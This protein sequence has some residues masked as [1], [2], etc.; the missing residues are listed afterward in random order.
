M[1]C[2]I[3]AARGVAHACRLWQLKKKT[4]LLLC[5]DNY[6]KARGSQKDIDSGK[7]TK[8]HKEPDFVISLAMELREKDIWRENLLALKYLCTAEALNK[9]NC[10]FN[11]NRQAELQLYMD[12]GTLHIKILERS[13]WAHSLCEFGIP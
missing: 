3:R 2:L 13:R 6:Q 9:D 11:A 1:I 4:V 5:T 12:M 7:G 10:P 8:W